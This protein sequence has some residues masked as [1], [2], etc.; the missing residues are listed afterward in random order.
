MFKNG[1]SELKNWI[2][3][4][5]TSGQ[6]NPIEI[7]GALDSRQVPSLQAKDQSWVKIS[8]VSASLKFR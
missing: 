6:V 2:M 5:L 7:S 4:H 3:V 8:G 1:F